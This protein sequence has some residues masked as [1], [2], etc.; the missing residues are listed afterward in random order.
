MRFISK[1]FLLF[2]LLI[3]SAAHAAEGEKGLGLRASAESKESFDCV[4]ANDGTQVVLNLFSKATKYVLVE[5]NL[6]GTN[7]FHTTTV[8]TNAGLVMAISS[9]LS[10]KYGFDAVNPT[11]HKV[12]Q[13]MNAQKSGSVKVYN[14]I[15]SYSCAPTQIR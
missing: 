5:I 6:R 12:L 4:S 11:F 9:D 13:E 10:K 3:M 7:I 2:T 15:A 8:K 14:K 1:W